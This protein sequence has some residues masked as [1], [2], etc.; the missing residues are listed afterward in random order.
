MLEIFLR[1]QRS[2]GTRVR[3][4]FSAPFPV[5]G[6]LNLSSVLRPPSSELDKRP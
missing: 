6:P 1:T 2:A 3:R 5:F 4:T